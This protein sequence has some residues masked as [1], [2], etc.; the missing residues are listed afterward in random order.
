MD[1]QHTLPAPDILPPSNQP[2][3]YGPV[4]TPVSQQAAPPHPIKNRKIPPIF[5]II[6]V[7]FV[8]IF[9]S[10]LFATQQNGGT[11]Q[12]PTPTPI[13]PTPTPVPIRGLTPYATESAFMK[14]ESTIDAL[15]GVIQG[16]AIQDP[17]IV[18]P[19]LDLPLGF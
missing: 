17:T 15:P 3:N 7:L 14:F 6:G 8:I 12:G 2:P 18:P 5:F 11:Q 1:D 16:A 4:H 13:S 9:G 19:V 10:L